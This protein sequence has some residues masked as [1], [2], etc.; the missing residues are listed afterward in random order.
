[1]CER[2]ASAVPVTVAQQLAGFL[3][4][5]EARLRFVATDRRFGVLDGSRF[6]RPRDARRAAVRLARVIRHD[7]EAPGAGGC[8]QGS[9]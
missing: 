2:L 4:H 6:S 9:R 8:A 3:V 5:D 7:G 1:M